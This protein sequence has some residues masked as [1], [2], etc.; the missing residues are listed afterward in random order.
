MAALAAEDLS[1]TLAGKHIFAPMATITPFL[2]VLV[3]WI[4]LFGNKLLNILIEK[5]M[6]VI[7]VVNKINTVLFYLGYHA[8]K[9]RPVPGDEASDSAMPTKKRM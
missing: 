6:K 3:F 1:A 5:Y 4:Y 7:V 8:P 2:L 9:L